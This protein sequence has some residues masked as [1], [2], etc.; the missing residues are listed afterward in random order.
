MNVSKPGVGSDLGRADAYENTAA[1][2]DEV[3]EV[4]EEQFAGAVVHV[5]GVPKIGRPPQGARSKKLLS[6]RLDPD[7][8]D[9]YRA[10]GAGWQ[11]RMNTFLAGRAQVVELV[12]GYEASAMAMR[13]MVAMLQSRDIGAVAPGLARSVESAERQIAMTDIAARAV[14]KVLNDAALAEV[15]SNRAGEA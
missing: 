14:R 4:T 11:G 13:E 7:V 8:I 9:A 3:P 2:Y 15:A 12:E 10:T 1:D 5:G 6:L